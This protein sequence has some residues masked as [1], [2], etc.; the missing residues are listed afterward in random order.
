[1]DALP[2]KAQKQDNAWVI[3]GVTLGVTAEGKLEVRACGN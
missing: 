1:V 3:E 2:G